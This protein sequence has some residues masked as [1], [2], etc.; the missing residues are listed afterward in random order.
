MTFQVN[1]I[2]KEAIFLKEIY[3]IVFIFFPKLDRRII[4]SSLRKPR[5]SILEELNEKQTWGPGSSLEEEVETENEKYWFEIDCRHR[6]NIEMSRLT[7]QDSYLMH[8]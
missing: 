1:I 6:I 8:A 3:L 5:K 2:L 4:F 7:N